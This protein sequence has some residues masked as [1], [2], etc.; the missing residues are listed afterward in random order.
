MNAHTKSTVLFWFLTFKKIFISQHSPFK[1]A[2]LI[3]RE[4]G[5]SCRIPDTAVPQLAAAVASKQNLVLP[6]R[7][8]LAF[9]LKNPTKFF[10]FHKESLAA[11]RLS[12]EPMSRRW[13]GGPASSSCL[14]LCSL[15][16][17]ARSAAAGSSPT[18]RHSPITRDLASDKSWF[19]VTT[20]KRNLFAL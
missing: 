1:I 17:A 5:S 20:V 4:A 2:Y 9:F 19:N 15:V 6:R 14:S 12:R 13:S 10:V 11:I 3:W 7:R 8:H 16:R 18:G